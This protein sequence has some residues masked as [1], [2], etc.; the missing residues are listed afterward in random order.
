MP[1]SASCLRSAG[2]RL[3]PAKYCTTLSASVLASKAAP[4]ALL[5]RTATEKTTLSAEVTCTCAR[6][7]A[8]VSG[9]IARCKWLN[10][11][12]STSW[13]STLS[14][15]A[16]A[17]TCCGA[18]PAFGIATVAT[19]EYVFWPAI[20][21]VADTM[22]ATNTITA[23]TRQWRKITNKYSRSSICGSRLMWG[24]SASGS[25]VVTGQG[26]GNGTAALVAAA[27]KSLWLTA[28]NPAETVAARAVMGVS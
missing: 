20:P 18:R 15:T 27:L 2:V 14:E 7:S 6:R 16:A 4:A 1:A 22:A 24:S 3:K 9:C 17:S 8:A 5:S 12:L 23:G 13:P 21:S 26:A 11:P 10:C 28:S 25:A 19:A